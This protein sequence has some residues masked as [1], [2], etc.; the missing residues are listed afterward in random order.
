MVP[1]VAGISPFYA[2]E[3][4]ETVRYCMTNQ[5]KAYK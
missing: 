2:H 4:E 3:G 5:T 1:P